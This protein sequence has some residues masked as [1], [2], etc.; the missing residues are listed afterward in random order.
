[1]PDIRINMKDGK[2]TIISVK[3]PITL[4]EALRKNGFNTES[5]CN[6]N[7]TCG[8]C[9]VLIRN[10][11]YPYTREEKKLLTDSEIYN[12]THLSCRVMVTSDL[13][14]TLPND[15]IN[16]SILTEINVT[17]I[18]G[19]NSAR[20]IAVSLSS[21]SI[22]DQRPDD[23][24]VLDELVCH[25][26]S[27]E[28]TDSTNKSNRLNK[29]PLNILRELPDTIRN[30]SCKATII[31]ILSEITGIERGNTEKTLYGAAID[32][33]TTTIAAYLY[34]LNNNKLI[35]V[36]SMLNPQRKYGSDVISRIG[37]SSQC[38][39]NR[40][41]MSECI[42]NAI[43]SLVKKL[44][45]SAGLNTYDIYLITLAGNTTMLHLFLGL[46]AG[47][48]A[49]AP[50]IPVT[51]AEHVFA[52]E[53]TG[54]AINPYGR[55][56]VLPSVSAY[57]GADTV[58]AVLS[59]GMHEKEEISLLVDIG[60]N[61][62]IV[63]GNKEALYA[64][65]TAA[66]PAFEGADISCGTGS[67]DGAISEVYI[68]NDGSKFEFKTIGGHEPVGLCGSGLIDAIACMLKTGLIDETGRIPYK[69]E[70]PESAAAFSDRLI[71]INQQ[72]AFVLASSKT[73]GHGSQIYITQKDIREVQN[74]KAA[75][76]AGIKILIMNAGYSFNDIDK[77]FL[78][79]G[80][81]NNLRI[82][83]AIVTGLLPE[84]LSGRIHAVGNAA[85][86]GAVYALLSE[87]EFGTSADIARK[88]HY[89]ELSA[90]ADFVSEY[91]ANMFFV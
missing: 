8:K 76:A 42:Q 46:P 5:P 88:I 32:I 14:V 79:G 64:C 90:N 78:A 22:T 40:I 17:G 61:G 34:D 51:L 77:V 36:E 39:N 18:Y 6:G 91:T 73:A 24:R 23:Q 69:D 12:G 68:S 48:L 2:A 82:E 87:K 89:L 38:I 62:E 28:S 33:G 55:I 58:A 85:G 53:E 3:E 37:Y 35:S 1:M 83:S 67:I 20:K 60:T 11:N 52:P 86:A 74:A 63:L 57:I 59:T 15:S 4:L 27:I 31:K 80:F 7:G 72:P 16:A 56:L 19:D 10:D 13:E 49:A 75:I 65:S 29:L 21:P 81:G 44:A 66:G 50:F 25:E 26:N 30:S 71:N 84:E 43:S 45:L 9:K 41:E 54:L 47:N 70:L